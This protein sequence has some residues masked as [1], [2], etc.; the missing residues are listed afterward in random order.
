MT[1]DILVLDLS[2]IILVYKGYASLYDVYTCFPLHQLLESLMTGSVQYNE[3]AW[4]HLEHISTMMDIDTINVESF[5]V[6]IELMSE[7]LD[8]HMTSVI[9]PEYDHTKYRFL[10]WLDQTSVILEVL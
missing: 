2:S 5:D 8:R 4:I 6:L 1:K 9:G 10:E 3:M 7:D